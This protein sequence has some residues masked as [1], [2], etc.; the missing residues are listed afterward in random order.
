MCE[1]C[2]AEHDWFAAGVPDSATGRLRA[3]SGLARAANALVANGVRVDVDP[4]SCGLR[5]KGAGGRTLSATGL[6]S[7]LSGIG[8]LL[9]QPLALVPHCRTIGRMDWALRL[10]VPLDWAIFGI[11]LG[12]LCM[13]YPEDVIAATG[14]VKAPAGSVAVAVR[15]GSIKAALTKDSEESYL[16]FTTA[17]LLPSAVR[18]SLSGTVLKVTTKAQLCVKNPQ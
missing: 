12:S 4:V 10:P 18:S 6:T 9:H 16:R 8:R 7:M 13:A 14:L 2:G 1:I 3:H 17:H 11:W 15:N 5:V